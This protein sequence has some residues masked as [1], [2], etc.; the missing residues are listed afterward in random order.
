MKFDP[1]LDAVEPILK[2]LLAFVSKAISRQ[3][4]RMFKPTK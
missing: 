4:I 1:L 3:Y 2:N